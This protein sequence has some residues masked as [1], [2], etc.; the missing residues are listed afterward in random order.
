MGSVD[1]IRVSPYYIDKEYDLSQ[2]DG[3]RALAMA[4]VSSGLA[5]EVK[6]QKPQQHK[7]FV[8]APDNKND[9]TLESAENVVT[10]NSGDISE[11]AINEPPR[12]RG[13]PRSTHP[14]NRN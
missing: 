2:S 3:H 8:S 4:F 6:I 12:G 10:E 9:N 1:G 11:R 13:R 5:D 7:A 14:N